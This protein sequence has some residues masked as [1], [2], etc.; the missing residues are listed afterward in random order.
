MFTGLAASFRWEKRV[1][2]VRTWSLTRRCFVCSR[3]RSQKC[4]CR[5]PVCC[6]LRRLKATTSGRMEQ[7]CSCVWD[8][9]CGSR[10]ALGRL[11]PGDARPARRFDKACCERGCACAGA[12]RAEI[13]QESACG[14]SRRACR[15][16]AVTPARNDRDVAKGASRAEA[17]GLAVPSEQ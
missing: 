11:V 3:S 15:T 2:V 7:S 17:S 4:F 5:T 10:C 9:R 14:T 8:R 6:S 16:I 12:I 13:N 1:V